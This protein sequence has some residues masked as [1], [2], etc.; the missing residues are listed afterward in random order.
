MFFL[1]ASYLE[2]IDN[3]QHQLYFFSSKRKPTQSELAF[4]AVRTLSG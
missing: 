2:A 1:R 3:G 4:A